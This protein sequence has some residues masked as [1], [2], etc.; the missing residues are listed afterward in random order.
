MTV[1]SGYACQI[2]PRKSQEQER[3]TV[4]NVVE[5]E[6][7]VGRIV[8]D[9]RTPQ[10]ITVLSGQMAVVPEGTLEVHE[11]RDYL[12]AIVRGNSPAWSGT[13]KS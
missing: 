1:E 2:M 3:L 13:W 6:M 11:V 5:G 12:E 4:I 8:H 9:E 10:T 7:G